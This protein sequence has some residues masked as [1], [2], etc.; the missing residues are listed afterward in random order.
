[1]EHSSIDLHIDLQFRLTLSKLIRVRIKESWCTLMPK[2]Q[3]E[4]GS[5]SLASKVIIW[6]LVLSMAI[7]AFASILSIAFN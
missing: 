5:T 2:K 4:K 1:M 7:P 3:R 6:V